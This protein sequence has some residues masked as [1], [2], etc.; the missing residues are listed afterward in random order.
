L[1]GDIRHAGAGSAGL[2]RQR[3]AAGRARRIRRFRRTHRRRQNRLPEKKPLRHIAAAFFHP[4]NAGSREKPVFAEDFP[5]P[6][7]NS[8]DL[9]L[10][11][12]QGDGWQSLYSFRFV[13]RRRR[14]TL[15]RSHKFENVI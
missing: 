2:G 15:H 8:N 6:F 11:T 13:S 4:A 3:V 7:F 5:E 14:A 9:L 12:A 1:A 10:R